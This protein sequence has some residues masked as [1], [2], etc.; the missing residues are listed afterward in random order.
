M[1]RKYAH[2][3]AAGTYY[4]Q[5]GVWKKTDS[6]LTQPQIEIL[7][8]TTKCAMVILHRGG[9]RL[10]NAIATE[11]FPHTLAEILAAEDIPRNFNKWLQSAAR[12][13]TDKDTDSWAQTT[14]AE[15]NKVLE[16]D[17][18]RRVVLRGACRM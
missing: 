17:K 2:T 1:N 4:K 11:T 6:V 14:L 3:K 8:S 5:D 12:S 10:D 9:Q 16:V 7:E 18:E 13:L 15:L